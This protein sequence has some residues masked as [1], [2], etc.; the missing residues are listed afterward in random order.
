MNLDLLVIDT[1]RSKA[2]AIH[3]RTLETLE[4]GGWENPFLEQA[5][6]IHGLVIWVRIT[7]FLM[8]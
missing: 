3:A 8:N 7:L 6:K 2:I 4:I 1:T 5:T